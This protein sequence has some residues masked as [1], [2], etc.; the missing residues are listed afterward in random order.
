QVV[1]AVLVETGGGSAG[2]GEVGAG[3]VHVNAERL[4]V[5]RLGGV[6]QIVWVARQVDAKDVA[7][8]RIE[9]ERDDAVG[10]LPIAGRTG[11]DADRRAGYAGHEEPRGDRAGGKCELAQGKPPVA[12]DRR[13]ARTLALQSWISVVVFH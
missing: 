7:S 1:I 3:I 10:D 11:V 12:A 2:R 8:R 5:R 4:V 13:A 6:D 9:V